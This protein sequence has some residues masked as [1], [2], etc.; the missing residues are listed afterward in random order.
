MRITQGQLKRMVREAVTQAQNRFS[1][2]EHRLAARLVD[3]L[4]DAIYDIANKRMKQDG[5]FLTRDEAE[6]YF[7]TLFDALPPGPFKSLE[8]LRAAH[9]E[10][11]DILMR[12][13]EDI[14]TEG[15]LRRMIRETLLSETDPSH[16]ADHSGKRHPAA[17]PGSPLGKYAFSPQRQRQSDPP[18]MERNRP[19]EN[20]LVRSIKGYLDGQLQLTRQQSELA[21]SFI[22]DGLYPDVF[23]EPRP[24]AYHRGMLLRTSDLEK[25][26]VDR[27]LIDP[28][29]PTM[30][31]SQKI[32][33]S[34]EV[35]S[36][37]GAAASS[38]S[39]SPSVARAFIESYLLEDVG[40]FYGV[41]FSATSDDNPGKFMDCAPFYDLDI[42]L[43]IDEVEKE[44]EVI[45]FGT[46]RSNL[47]RLWKL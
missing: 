36:Q 27:E 1:D 45:G 21:M 15:Q 6:E 3:R 8:D 44:E 23:R 33:G 37:D 12:R 18:P 10:F 20:A 25:M 14:T 39:Y 29:L 30:S 13:A 35:K 16:P 19:V 32:P 38:W 9:S 17:P 22:R 43:R 40:D 34:F 47:V 11:T 28:D 7:Q 42:D 4:N 31:K 24:G 5:H 2:K 41:V 26:G 46:I